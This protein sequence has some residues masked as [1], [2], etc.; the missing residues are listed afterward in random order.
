MAE[1]KKPQKLTIDSLIEE[2][3]SVKNDTTIGNLHFKELTYEQQRKILTRSAGI[4]D[5]LAVIKNT[6]NNYIDSN[7]E[8][9]DDMVSTLN[10]VTLDIRPFILN[11]LRTISIG[12]EI[13]DEGK[14]YE[15]YTVQEEDLTPKIEP[16]TFER[17][18]FKM[19]L[20]VP[21]LRTD[22]MYNT[23]LVAALSTYKNRQARNI[24]E[25]EAG[26]IEE[27]YSFYENM[28]Y[29]KTITIGGTDFEYRELS[30][31]DKIN[32]LNQFPQQLI[33]VIY[34]YRKQVDKCVEKAYRAINPEDG[35][36]LDV[37]NDLQ[38]F[39]INEERNS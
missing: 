34:K 20:E 33:A 3:K 27:L 31:A 5:I 18:G 6:L 29:I 4:V 26:E 10:T 11:V 25:L 12:K 39:L 8:Y 37:V 32:I 28:K 23:L 15:L 30:T 38:L 22:N 14:K 21:N 35:T 1:K 2:L 16:F 17:E 13:T 24:T 19:V 36:E 9:T 7:V